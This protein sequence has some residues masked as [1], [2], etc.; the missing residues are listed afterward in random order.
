MEFCFTSEQNDLIEAARDVLTGEITVERLRALMRGEAVTPV[1]PQLAELGLLG[2]MAPHD[3]GGL[4]QNLAVMAAVAEAAGYVAL[5]EPLVDIAG[6]S[7]PM[8]LHHGG[9]L[10][11]VENIVAGAPASFVTADL[12]P[13]MAAPEYYNRLVTI[14]DQNYHTASFEAGNERYSIDPLRHL[15]KIDADHSFAPSLVHGAVLSAAQLVGLSC[16]MRDMAVAYAADR[17]QFGV[18]IGSFQGVKHQLANVHTQIE[19]TRPMIWQ[20]ALQHGAAVHMA[21]L[22]AIDCA[23]LAAETAIQVFGGMGYTFEVDLHMFMKRAWALSGEWGDKNYHARQLDHLIQ[24]GALTLGPGESFTNKES[25]N[26]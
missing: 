7:V 12:R 6:V 9:A 8:A 20:A 13:Y 18:A 17:K 19:F 23:T 22:A 3:Q 10:A 16:R 25:V 24:S 11:D 14:T 5:P 15:V 21:K 4:S 26:G 1:W 2:I